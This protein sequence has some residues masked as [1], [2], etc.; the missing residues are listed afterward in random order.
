MIKDSGIGFRNTGS[1]SQELIKHFNPSEIILK[2]SLLF[3]FVFIKS[4]FFSPEFYIQDWID[5][6]L[7]TVPVACQ[8]ANVL[9]KSPTAMMGI[10]VAKS[11]RIPYFR[12]FTMP[13][14][15]TS[16]STHPFAVTSQPTRRERNRAPV[17]LNDNSDVKHLPSVN[18]TAPGSASKLSKVMLTGE[19]ELTNMPF[20]YN[21]SEKIAPK[22]SDWDDRICITGYWFRDKQEKVDQKEIKGKICP[23]LQLFIQKARDKGK[24]IIYIGFGSPLQ[25][26]PK[27]Q[28]S[29]IHFVGAVPHK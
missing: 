18:T 7:V 22:P 5:E 27:S 20:L 12:V 14:T 21:F 26:P 10:H 6:L 15:P 19:Q 4:G 17:T 25:S 23:D 28:D 16:V 3:C 2:L 9:I 1:N 8:G 11:M 29:P 24:K 13:W